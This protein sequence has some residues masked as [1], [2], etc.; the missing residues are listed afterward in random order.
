MEIL[1]MKN[2]RTK[3]ENSPE[4]FTSRMDVMTGEGGVVSEISDSAIE[5][6]QYEQQRESSKCLPIESSRI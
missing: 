2:V 6:I 4:G 3:I 5:M 1:G